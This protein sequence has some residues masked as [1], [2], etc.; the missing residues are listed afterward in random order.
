MGFGVPPLAYTLSS[1][2]LTLRSVKGSTET[3]V[4][5]KSCVD[6]AVD[7]MFQLDCSKLLDDCLLCDVEYPWDTSPDA[8]KDAVLFCSFV[9]PGINCKASIKF[10][11]QIATNKNL[12]LWMDG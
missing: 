8:P 5:F 3:E 9:G 7:G 10:S 2:L 12:H 1:W 11:S 6:C 4:G